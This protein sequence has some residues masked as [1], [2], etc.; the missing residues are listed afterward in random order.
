[1]SMKLLKVEE[2]VERLNVKVSTVRS[3]ILT[4]HIISHRVGRSVRIAS[5]EIERILSNG[6][7]PAREPIGGDK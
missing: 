1:M 3:W 5:T 6:L 4:I 2:V 7:R